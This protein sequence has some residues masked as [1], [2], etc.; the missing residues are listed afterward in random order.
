MLRD[1]QPWKSQEI[2]HLLQEEFDVEYHPYYLGEFLRKLGLSYAK[3]RPKRP[4]RP[5]NPEEFLDDRVDDALVESR[6]VRRRS[7]RGTA[8]SQDRGLSGWI[9]HTER[10]E[11]G[12]LERN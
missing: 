6:L 4:Y 7:T 9:L 11:Y 12:S 3:P 10:G 5:E 1:G 2:Q 8:V